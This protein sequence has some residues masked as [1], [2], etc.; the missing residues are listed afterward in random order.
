V[1]PDADPDSD[2]YLMQMQIGV[3]KMMRIQIQNTPANHIG[4]V[5]QRLPTFS[6]QRVVD[7]AKVFQHPVQT[8]KKRGTNSAGEVTY[9]RCT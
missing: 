8:T 7:L 1:D 2:F 4:T 5:P 3:S 6:H 9:W